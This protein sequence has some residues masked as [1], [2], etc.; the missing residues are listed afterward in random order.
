M[1]TFIDINTSI[2]NTVIGLSAIIYA[3]LKDNILFEDIFEE[4]KKAYTELNIK[5][6]FTNDDIYKSLL[7]LYSLGKIDINDNGEVFKL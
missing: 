3:R 5:T 4:I 6:I 1:N 2:Q 7:L